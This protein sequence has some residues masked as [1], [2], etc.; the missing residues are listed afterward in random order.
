MAKRVAELFDHADA[1]LIE[2]QIADVWKDGGRYAPA[3]EP[4]WKGD[5]RAYM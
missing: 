3:T 1:D 2:S 4:V 5:A